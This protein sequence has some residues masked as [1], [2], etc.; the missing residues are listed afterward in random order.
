[1]KKI[2]LILILVFSVNL[3]A[4]APIS[5]FLETKEKNIVKI[6]QLFQGKSGEVPLL[7]IT[8]QGKYVLKVIAENEKNAEYFVTLNRYWQDEIRLN[9]IFLTT[10]GKYYVEVDNK[11]YAL[12]EYFENFQSRKYYEDYEFSQIGKLAATIHNINP[13]IINP[14]TYF[15]RSAILSK[16]PYDPK[17]QEVIEKYDKI[18]KYFFKTHIHNDLHA[19][20]VDQYYRV[21]DL[22]IAQYDYRIHEFLKIFWYNFRDINFNVWNMIDCLISYQ[23]HINIPLNVFEI[24]G[25]ILTIQS[26]MFAE[27][28]VF[29]FNFASEL[30][31]ITCA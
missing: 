29:S 14:R 13:Y 4:L 8:K 5:M 30:K 11:Y 15:D 27:K 26:R 19:G 31:K 17:I 16:L 18:K 2:I 9:K 12:F 28:K 20:N 24:E 25:I 10:D 1:M 3:Q 6:L 7:I 23:K 21:I 22:G